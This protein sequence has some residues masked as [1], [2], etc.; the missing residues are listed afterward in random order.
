[1]FM[2][3][4]CPDCGEKCRVPESVFGQQ[5]KC[6]KCAGPIP[7]GPAGRPPLVRAA[8]QVAAADSRPGE[9]IRYSCPRCAKPLESPVAAA[10]QKVNCPDCGQRLLVPQP[11]LPVVN[12]PVRVIAAP[13]PAPSPPVTAEVLPAVLPAEA[14]AP[15]T[16]M[17]REYCLECGKNITDRP[18]VHTC[19]DCGSLFCSAMCYRE[20]HY[21]AHSSRR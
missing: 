13:P 17:R 9:S 19:P 18:R 20:H 3:V 4:T 10:G 7:C 1:M 16:P 12:V 2:N 11:S 14:A 21:H 15:D 8:S 6:P 5:V